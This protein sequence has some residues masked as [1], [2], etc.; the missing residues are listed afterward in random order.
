MTC[1]VTLIYYLA[2]SITLGTLSTEYSIEFWAQLIK[3]EPVNVPFWA[4]LIASPFVSSFMI[5]IAIITLL[6]SFVL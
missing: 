6:V 5:P 1:L 2:I 4:C 3:N